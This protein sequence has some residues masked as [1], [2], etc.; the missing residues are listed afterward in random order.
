MRNFV[1][2]GIPRSVPVIVFDGKSEYEPT[3]NLEG[4]EYA[5]LLP[6][7]W[8]REI[9]REKKPH[10]T[11]LIVRMFD[12][13]YP[14]P[15]RNFPPL[16]DMCNRIWQYCADEERRCVLYIDEYQTVCDEHRTSG[17]MHRLVTM[18]RV[19][20]IG[21][22]GGSQRPS[23]IPRVFVSEADHL[24]NFFLRDQADRD[25]AAEIV[26]DEARNPP[27]PGEHD[28][29]YRGPSVGD[30]HPFLVHQ[31][32]DGEMSLDRGPFEEYNA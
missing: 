31:G 12:D 23:L 7:H 32:D 21:V 18:G 14:E 1:E 24:F 15:R 26:G 29:W 20:D 4:W 11:R 28:F 5:E 19:R 30:V 2:L 16:V 9:S 22:W 13:W 27:G 17:A 3:R 10:L 25:R 6:K 8:E